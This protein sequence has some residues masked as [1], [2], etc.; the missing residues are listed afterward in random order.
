MVYHYPAI[1]SKEDGYWFAE[2]PDLNGAT[3]EAPTR[4]AVFDAAEEMAAGWIMDSL[5]RGEPLPAPTYQLQ[6][7]LDPAKNEACYIVKVDTD[8]IVSDKDTTPVKKTLAIPKWVNEAAEKRNIN[9]S[10]TLRDALIE[11]LSRLG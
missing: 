11:K 9:F 3:T 1:I 10:A 2:F 8:A 5:E 6:R 4:E 7:A